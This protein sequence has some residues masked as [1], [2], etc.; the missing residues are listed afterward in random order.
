[1]GESDSLNP[2]LNTVVMQIRVRGE[3][4]II[5]ACFPSKKLIPVFPVCPS[6]RVF[7]NYLD[8]YR[9]DNPEKG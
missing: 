1:M 7:K 2:A 4:L 3:S 9:G 5:V 6:F 8:C